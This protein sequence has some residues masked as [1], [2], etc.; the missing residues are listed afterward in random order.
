MYSEN[1]KFSFKFRSVEHYIYL[2][3]KN[4]TETEKFPQ[5]LFAHAKAYKF[6][7]TAQCLKK[8]STLF[9]NI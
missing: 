5:N 2:C 4:L 8:K 9:G 1:L 3:E 7:E 6:L